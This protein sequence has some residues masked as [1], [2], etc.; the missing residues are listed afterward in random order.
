MLLKTKTK[1]TPSALFF[2]VWR[3]SEGVLFIQV[4]ITIL[5]NGIL[6]FTRLIHHILEIW[7]LRF[8]FIFK[9]ETM[10]WRKAVLVKRE[11]YR[12]NRSLFWRVK[13]IILFG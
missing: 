13:Q 10:V 9:H 7:P 6:I 3:V 1:Y 5:I 8:L 11:D 12:G 2:I 4:I